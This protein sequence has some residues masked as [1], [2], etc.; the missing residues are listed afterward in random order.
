[1]PRTHPEHGKQALY[2]SC[3]APAFMQ[4][5]CSCLTNIVLHDIHCAFA[6]FGVITYCVCWQNVCYGTL[7]P[8]VRGYCHTGRGASTCFSGRKVGVGGNCGNFASSN[9][10]YRKPH[11]HV[12]SQPLQ[13]GFSNEFPAGGDLRGVLRKRKAPPAWEGAG[14]RA[15]VT[16]P[17]GSCYQTSP[18][19]SHH[20]WFC[21]V[22][23]S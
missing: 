15:G 12:L 17:R 4:G 7:C 13:G 11:S 14:E 22:W 18:G 16:V 3:R 6:L 10:G 8:H 9:V 23:R 21:C 19:A 20:C 1:M 2:L 5:M